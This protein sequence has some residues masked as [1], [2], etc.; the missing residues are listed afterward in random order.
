MLQALQ[1]SVEPSF[2]VPLCKVSI[3]IT[4]SACN[5][6]L[7]LVFKEPGM[8]HAWERKKK[9]YTIFLK[10]PKENRTL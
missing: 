6:S 4:S 10:K 1:K 8:W 9:A 5:I 7:S 3:S 2:Y